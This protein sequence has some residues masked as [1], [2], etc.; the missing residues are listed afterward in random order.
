MPLN[1]RGNVTGVL[2]LDRMDGRRSRSNELEPAKLFA[3]MA[4]IAIQNARSYEEMERQAISDGLTGLHNYRHFHETLEAEVRRAGTLRET[5]CLLMMGLDHFKAVN[6]TVG[7][8][9]ATKCC[10]P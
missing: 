7:H 3:N 4:A 6:D 5:F 10:A 2:C 8:R 1:V 9:R